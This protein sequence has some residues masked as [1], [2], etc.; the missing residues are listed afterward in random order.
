[1]IDARTA[2]AASAFAALAATAASASE[3]MGKE[4]YM[5]ACAA[6][7]GESALGNGPIAEFLNVE[8]PGLTRLSADNG[9]AFPMLKVINIIDG[10]SVVRA[11]G[12]PMPIWGEIFKS[13]A[14]GDSMVF[15]GA[16]A[17]ARGK[18]L[19]IAYYLESIQE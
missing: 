18:V 1:M 4:A 17:L 10:R 7:H 14:L 13:Q 15:G 8:V 11:H 2:I 3:D 9:G 16:E 19:S 12:D 6:C 5:Q